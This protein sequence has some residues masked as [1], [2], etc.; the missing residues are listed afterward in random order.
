M[1]KRRLHILIEMTDQCE[2]VDGLA[3]PQ[4]RNDSVELFEPFFIDK[5]NVAENKSIIFPL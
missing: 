4:S 5:R 1:R 2:L 3:S